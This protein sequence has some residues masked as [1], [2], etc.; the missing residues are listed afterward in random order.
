M[1]RASLFGTSRVSVVERTCELPER[2]SACQV[3]EVCA[4]CNFDNDPVEALC[5]P[6]FLTLPRRV[7]PARDRAFDIDADLR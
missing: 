2:P 1:L 7:A 6:C 5:G 4:V 3:L